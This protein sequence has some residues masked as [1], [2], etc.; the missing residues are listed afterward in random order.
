MHS[1]DYDTY[2]GVAAHW[3]GGHTAA[4]EWP[5]FI[6]S[7]G[8]SGGGGG[9]HHAH[10]YHVHHIPA[11][12]QFVP[13]PVHH[14]GHKEHGIGHYWPFLLLGKGEKERGMTQ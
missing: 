7:K 10:D 3:G 4:H 14:G 1:R 11:H 12:V 6:H 5:H 8:H 13:Y 2:T 9:G